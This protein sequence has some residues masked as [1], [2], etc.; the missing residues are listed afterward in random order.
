[1]AHA[2]SVGMIVQRAGWGENVVAASFLHDSMEDVNRYGMIMKRDRLIDLMGLE[3]AE[4]VIQVTEE[5]Y[6]ASGRKRSWRERKEDYLESIRNGSEEVAAISLADKLHN[7]WSINEA[8]ARGFNLFEESDRWEALNAGAEEQIWF[9]E[10]I[11]DATSHHD[12]SR[13]DGLKLRLAVEVDRFA[14][15]TGLNP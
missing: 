4:L 7:L 12:D 8:L 6:D 2:T 13:L 5:K 10:H 3:V 15:Q 1:M 11:L 9:Y 14:R